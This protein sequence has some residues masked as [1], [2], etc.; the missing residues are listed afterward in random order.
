[1]QELEVQ[2]LKVMELEVEELEIQKL[3][4][5]ELEVKE[6]EIRNTCPMIILGGKAWMAA[7]SG[8]RVLVM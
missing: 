4:V 3:K 5:W 7:T 1:M 8:A 2:E 6:K